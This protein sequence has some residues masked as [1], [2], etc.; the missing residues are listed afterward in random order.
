M[1]NPANLSVSEVLSTYV[2]K[3]GILSANMGYATAV[4]LFNAVIG[5][6]FVVTGNWIAGRTSEYGLW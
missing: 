5:L 4:D 1:Q 2:Y 3:Q 6:F